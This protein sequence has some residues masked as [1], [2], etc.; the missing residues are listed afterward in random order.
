MVEHSA[1]NRVVMGSSPIMP[2][3]LLFWRNNKRKKETFIIIISKQEALY[4]N[5]QGV[6]YG[7]NGIKSTTSRHSGK[8]YRLCTS[9]RNMKLLKT[10]RD[11]VTLK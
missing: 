4:L 3:H 5:S 2:V 10:Y 9:F 1:V 7:E 6:P 8:A 11:N